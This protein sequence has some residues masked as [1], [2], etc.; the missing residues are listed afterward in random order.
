M[1]WLTK[2]SMGGY[3]T[4]LIALAALLWSTDALFRLPLTHDLSAYEIVLAEHALALVFVIPILIRGRQLVRALNR[5]QWLAVLFIGVAASA[6]ATVAFTASFSYVGPSVSILLQKLQPLV[7]FGL[8]YWLLKE[9]LPAQFWWWAVLAL[10]GAYFVS[11]PEIWPE[12]TL[13]DKGT[14]GVLLALIAAAIWGGA[15]VFGRSLLDNIPYPLVTALRFISALPVL[16]ILVFVSRGSLAYTSLSLKDFLFLL[17]I[18][19]G[20]GFGAMYLYYRGLKVTKASVSA[21]LELIWP[22][23]AVVL[24][25]FVL[26][27]TL[28]VSQIL[29]GVLLVGSIARLTLW[30]QPQ[31]IRNSKS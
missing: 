23:S 27:T 9:R 18:M 2:T 13:Y 17:I 28:T 4:W 22:L 19:L 20:P 29:G 25:W 5:R 7:T 3:R 16:L 10:I 24:N 12:L 14:I 11:F 30:Q 31:Q 21:L 26:G 1:R 6:L 8:A 15:T